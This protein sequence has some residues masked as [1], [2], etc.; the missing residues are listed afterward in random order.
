M[1]MKKEVLGIFE[2]EFDG[3][4]RKMIHHM[5]FRNVVIVIKITFRFNVVG[6]NWKVFSE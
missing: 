6:F 4:K 5:L 3:D 1:L 2:K